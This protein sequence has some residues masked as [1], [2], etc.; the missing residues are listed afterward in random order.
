VD[1]GELLSYTNIYRYDKRIG[2]YTHV[3]GNESSD[4]QAGEAECDERVTKAKPS[5]FG[6]EV[7]V[8]AINTTLV[9]ATLFWEDTRWV[10]VPE[11]P[12]PSR[13]TLDVRKI[14]KRK[15]KTAA[16]A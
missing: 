7:H 11:P 8:S 15:K 6:R 1:N 16:S 5:E 9:P 10:D 12:F 4:V 2:R 3:I 14:R 13:T